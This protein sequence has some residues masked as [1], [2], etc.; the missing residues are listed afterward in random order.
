[1]AMKVEVARIVR[2]EG[3]M[4]PDGVAVGGDVADVPAHRQEFDVLRAG[5]GGARR[6]PILERLYL[7]AEKA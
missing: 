5:A 6:A 3:G 7:A 2:M 1:M 4:A